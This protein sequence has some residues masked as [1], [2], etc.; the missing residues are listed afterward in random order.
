MAIKYKQGSETDF[1]F[2]HSNDRSHVMHLSSQSSCPNFVV[3]I[4]NLVRG[5]DVLQ[6]K[7]RTDEKIILSTGLIKAD[8]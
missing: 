3:S 6:I 8:Q 1:H 2:S 7:K 4:R 5:N